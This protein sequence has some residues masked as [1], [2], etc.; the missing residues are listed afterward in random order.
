MDGLRMIPCT[1]FDP[2]IEIDNYVE[3]S[4]AKFLRIRQ[5]NHA[6]LS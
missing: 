6:S 2:V 3:N 4:K 5:N 1:F